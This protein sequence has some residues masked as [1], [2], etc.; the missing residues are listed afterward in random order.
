M[1]LEFQIVSDIHIERFYPEVPDFRTFITKSSD[2]LILAGD[3]GRLEYTMQ[4]FNFLKSL[5]VEFKKIY[6]V[7][8]NNEYYSSKS[9]FSYLKYLLYQ[10]EKKIPNLIVLDD[11]YVDIDDTNIRLYGTTLWSYIPDDKRLLNLPIRVDGSSFVNA[12][13][14]NKQHF[15]SLYTLEKTID[16]LPEDKKIVIIT[17]HPPTD[18]GCLAERHL[19]DPKNVY[20]HNKLDRLFCDKIDTWIFGHTHVNCDYT[21]KDVGTRIVSNQFLNKENTYIHNKVIKIELLKDNSF[22]NSK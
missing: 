4:Y 12:T 21:S 14:I 16:N 17:H 7:P 9:D 19:N 8:G 6:L 13:W 5:S 1:T 22:T 18:K 15:N 10:I 11:K 3:I 2:Y 20:Y